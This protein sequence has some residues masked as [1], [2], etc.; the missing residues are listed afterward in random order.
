[1]GVDVR[2]RYPTFHAPGQTERIVTL[3]AE[4]DHIAIGKGLYGKGVKAPYH[5]HKGEEYVLILHGRGIFRTRSDE[6]LAKQGMTLRFAPNEEHEF[7]NR[8]K[9]PLEFIFVYSNPKD[10]VP[11]KGN[12]VRL[13]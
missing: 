12:W 11:L 4:D 10:M 3:I 9:E 2:K 5:S 1:M 7:E 8:W 13:K 6:V